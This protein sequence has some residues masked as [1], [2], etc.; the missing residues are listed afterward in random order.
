[1][2]F[3]K[4]V[5]AYIVVHLWLRYMNEF[6]LSCE[7]MY[8]SALIGA[9][10]HGWEPRVMI[11]MLLVFMVF[12]VFIKWFSCKME[13]N[14]F[15][16]IFSDKMKMSE[17]F[18]HVAE[19][20]SRWPAPPTLSEPHARVAGQICS[21]LGLGVRGDRGWFLGRGLWVWGM[22]HSEAKYGCDRSETKRHA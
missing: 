17:S 16:H 22:C 6:Q 9:C 2:S 18:R 7:C 4:V 11:C 20:A 13:L 10:P 21:S 12:M 14:D 8:V 1:M 15:T 3:N 19:Q 5:S